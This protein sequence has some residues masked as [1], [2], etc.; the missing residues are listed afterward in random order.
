VLNFDRTI[1]ATIIDNS[2]ALY[3]RYKVTTDTNITF[4][5]YCDITNYPL[6][7]RVYVRI[8]ENDYTKQKTI[9]GRYV[10]ENRTAIITDIKTS[11]IIDL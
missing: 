4:I 9:T 3:G 6:Y 10:Q 7:E 5:A 2:E 1:I 11:T 8:P